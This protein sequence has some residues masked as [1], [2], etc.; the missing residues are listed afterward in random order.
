MIQAILLKNLI[1]F[2]LGIITA[3][4]S[5]LG[6]IHYTQKQIN[7][8]CPP[9]EVNVSCPPPQI[10]PNSLDI[11]KMKNNKG[12]I[13]IHQHYTVTGK[14]DSLL[15]KQTLIEVERMLAALRVV[16]CRK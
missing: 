15:L 3:T 8:S 14:T 2:I 6:I 9:P 1:P 5:I 4:T 13:E 11:D 7:V 16:K 12:K 10:N